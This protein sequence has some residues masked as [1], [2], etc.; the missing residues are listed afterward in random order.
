MKRAHTIHMEST[1][2]SHKRDGTTVRIGMQ[3]SI[4]VEINHVDIAHWT[5]LTRHAIHLNRCMD[6]RKH[7]GRLCVCVCA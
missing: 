4:T 1:L 3:S 6:K 7:Q 5:M 2:K